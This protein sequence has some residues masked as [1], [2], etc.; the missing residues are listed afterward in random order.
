MNKVPWFAP[1]L[2]GLIFSIGSLIACQAPAEPLP[3]VTVTTAPRPLRIGL[4]DDASEFG[5]LVGREFPLNASN[6]DLQFI[7]GN[8][9]VLL[10]DLD[11][12]FLDAALVYSVPTGE[13]Y[14][15]NPVALDG[16]VFI[17]HPDNSLKDV[18]LADAKALFSGAVKNWSSFA[19]PELEVKVV[20][21][22]PGA[23]VRIILEEQLMAGLPIAGSSSI[24]PSGQSLRSIVL[25]EPGAIGISMMGNAEE[26]NVL[27]IGGITAIPAHT[28][29]QSYPLTAPIYFVSIGEP[30]GELRGFLAWLQSP[31]G[32]ARIGE[33]YGQVR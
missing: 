28:A 12:S 16:L 18:S 3:E 4:S 31:E 29:D 19:G 23:G 7:E 6:V 8:D 17:V 10:E 14:W 32:Q 9:Q 21:R 20:S 27:S 13:E 15:F 25:K 30:D 1:T 22:E 2:V 33:K 5:D 11:T 26:M 24:A